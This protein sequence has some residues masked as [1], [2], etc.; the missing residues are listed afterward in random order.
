MSAIAVTVVIFLIPSAQP[1]A[2][3]TSEVPLIDIVVEQPPAPTTTPTIQLSTCNCVMFRL[4]DI[5]D[6]YLADDQIAIME[7]FKQE[8][9]SL[10][11]GIIA[12]QFGNDTRLVN[13]IDANRNNNL[14]IAN[15]GWNHE[16]FT[17]LTREQ[18]SELMRIANVKIEKITGIEPAIFIAPYNSANEDTAQAAKDN[19]MA[20]ISADLDYHHNTTSSILHIPQT[21]AVTEYQNQNGTWNTIPENALIEEI[22]GDIESYGFALVTI[23]PSDDD[24]T[25]IEHLL[26]VL[27]RE[28]VLIVSMA[29]I[30]TSSSPPPSSS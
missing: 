13:Y 16:D 22:K 20:V 27:Q 26:D 4:D 10:T 8:N 24:L 15:H 23:H 9:V 12:H 21:S 5:Q 7:T 28:D 1:P 19:G 3:S 11:I 2:S 29:D 30:I 18:Q 6:Y 25:D 17:V 14:T